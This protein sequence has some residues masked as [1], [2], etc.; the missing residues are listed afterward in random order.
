MLVLKRL[1]EKHTL[2]K[3]AAQTNKRTQN[4]QE[5]DVCD[6]LC[7]ADVGGARILFS[8]DGEL[9]AANTRHAR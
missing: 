6:I 8:D 9:P 5:L 3:L 2:I 7:V 4:K 1:P